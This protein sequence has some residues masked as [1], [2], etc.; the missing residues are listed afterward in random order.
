MPGSGRTSGYRRYVKFPWR[1]PWRASVVL[2]II[3]GVG[4]IGGAINSL[5]QSERR[6]GAMRSWIRT[7]A[8]RCVNSEV[9]PSSNLRGVFT[10]VMFVYA[11][12]ATAYGSMN[13]FGRVTQV[14][15][16]GRDAAVGTYT[17]WLLS[18]EFLFAVLGLAIFVR[19]FI[20]LA[21]Y[22]R[23]KREFGSEMPLEHA[24]YQLSNLLLIFSAW[25]VML[26]P[27]VVL[28]LLFDWDLAD[29]KLWLFDLEA[30]LERL[31]EQLD[32]VP[33]LVHF[34]PFIAYFS[35]RIIAGFIGY[36]WHRA[37]H[38]WR[39]LW[40]LIHRPHH[41]PVRISEMTSIVA[42]DTGIGF[43]LKKMLLPVFY[44]MLT[45]LFSHDSTSIV[46][47]VIF[48]TLFELVYSVGLGAIG[49]TLTM[50]QWSVRNKWVR[51]GFFITAGGP[52]HLMHHSNRPEHQAV[53][54][55]FCPLYFWDIVFGTFVKPTEETP[56]T[57]LTNDPDV[58]MNPVRL[59]YSGFGEMY[60]ELKCNKGFKDRLNILFGSS[61]FTPPIRVIY[62][63][64]VQPPASK[65][66]VLEPGAPR[67]QGA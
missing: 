67:L 21:G 7:F 48:V 13:F 4:D 39:P 24:A 51:W 57:G 9:R 8:L 50:Y 62:H 1:V 26:V 56:N 12:I 64:K 2:I 18:P 17:A 42:D 40:F 54:L 16:E 66:D 22:T 46:E 59:I 58:Y 47:I 60:M 5:L 31:P 15:F 29:A 41:T 65:A 32:R 61:H 14:N 3:G 53:N 45:K 6:T 20:T 55:G 49:H 63:T 30:H 27:G 38:Q 44:G 52:Y 34:S 36:W 10:A 11:G 25:F 43:I 33:T 35:S 23:Q 19:Y 28:F 37:C